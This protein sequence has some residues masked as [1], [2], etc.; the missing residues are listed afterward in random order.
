MSPLYAIEYMRFLAV[1]LGVHGRVF[2]L[3]LSSSKSHADR[4]VLIHDCRGSDRCQNVPRFKK[5]KN[6]CRVSLGNAFMPALEACLDTFQSY[7][8][9]SGT[10]SAPRTFTTPPRGLEELCTRT[11]RRTPQSAGPAGWGK[12]ANPGQLFM[13]PIIN[14][15]F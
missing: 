2:N 5:K 15:G 3:I 6:L 13:C 7:P 14:F 1:T 8:Y 9:V 10:A 12:R 11:L 4:K